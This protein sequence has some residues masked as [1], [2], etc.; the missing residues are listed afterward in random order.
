MLLSIR[1]TPQKKIARSAFKKVMKEVFK[2]NE[3]LTT[4]MLVVFNQTSMQ[5]MKNLTRSVDENI[6]RSF[7]NI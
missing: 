3:A 5:P 4:E 1:I 7:K 6:L 2:F